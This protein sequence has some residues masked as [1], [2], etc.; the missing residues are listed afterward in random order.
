M[1]HQKKSVEV[2]VH[3]PISPKTSIFYFGE[4]SGKKDDETNIL[5]EEPF[6]KPKRTF[7]YRKYPISYFLTIYQI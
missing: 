3:S 5:N 6:L 2:E 4:D 1:S 7:V